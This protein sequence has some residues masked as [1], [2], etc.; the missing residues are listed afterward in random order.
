VAEKRG[1]VI[2]STANEGEVD[3]VISYHRCTVILCKLADRENIYVWDLADIGH[4]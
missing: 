3:E 1:P 4:T 2:R